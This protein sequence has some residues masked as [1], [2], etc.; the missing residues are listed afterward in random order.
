MVAVD[1]EDRQTN[2][3]AV[4]VEVGLPAQ[5]LISRTHAVAFPRHSLIHVTYP[6]ACNET[7]HARPGHANKALIL[8]IRG[9]G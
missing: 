3:E 8:L 9:D 4:T 6:A 5:P 7:C 2:L 1:G